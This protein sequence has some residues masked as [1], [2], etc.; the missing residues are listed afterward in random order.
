MQG[1]S[2]SF[3]KTD[4]Y[5][6]SYKATQPLPD[7]PFNEMMRLAVKTSEQIGGGQVTIIDDEREEIMGITTFGGKIIA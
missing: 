1:Y 5:G 2:I 4:Q 3:T 6:L 7:I